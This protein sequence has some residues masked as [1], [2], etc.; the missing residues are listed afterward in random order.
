MTNKENIYFIHANGYPASAYSPLF[1]I[2][3]KSYNINH[4]N[5]VSENIDINNLKNW[6][7]FHENFTKELKQIKII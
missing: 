2:I 4:F 5:L 6:D 3:Q 7:P 1:T